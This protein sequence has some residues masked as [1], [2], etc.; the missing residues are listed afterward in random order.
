MPGKNDGSF[1]LK[2]GSHCPI[3]VCD[4]TLES[5]DEPKVLHCNTCGRN[6]FIG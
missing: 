1:L 4:G 2:A 5:T 3:P 6:I